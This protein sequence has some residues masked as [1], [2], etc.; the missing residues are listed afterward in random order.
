MQVFSSDSAQQ[1]SKIVCDSLDNE[2]KVSAI[3][4]HS[5]MKVCSAYSEALRSFNYSVSFYTDN[6]LS[7]IQFKPV[8]RT[9]Q[10]NAA[11][12]YMNV[13]KS[14]DVKALSVAMLKSYNESKLPVLQAIGPYSV[15]TCIKAYAIASQKSKTEIVF[16]ITS[17]K[18]EEFT[19]FVFQWMEP[20]STN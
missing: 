1:V 18:T 5:I 17:K 14:T 9:E 2:K 15:N 11:Y 12:V 19:Q 10:S 13:G 20:H 16:S 8:K 6:S 7:G 4:P 3:G